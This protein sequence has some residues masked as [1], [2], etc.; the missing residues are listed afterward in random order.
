M[1]NV[2]YRRLNALGGRMRREILTIDG[3][4]VRRSTVIARMAERTEQVLHA[5]T[6]DHWR[7]GQRWYADAYA[8][9]AHVGMAAGLT[10]GPDAVRFGADII[11]I[12]SPGCGWEHNVEVA[13]DV[14]VGVR[15]PDM[16]YRGYG[17]MLARAIEYRDS[18][19]NGVLTVNHAR[20]AYL[21]GQKVSAFA[22]TIES[23][24]TFHEAVIDRHMAEKVYGMRRAKSLENV[25]VFD[26]LGDGVARVA[27]KVGMF[28]HEVQA[29]VWCAV[30]PAIVWDDVLPTPM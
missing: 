28:P 13:V 6:A 14:A 11:A 3:A 10:E 7:E 8:M 27:R 17:N 29:I 4:K 22:R 1:R 18:V 30:R 19:V 24:F 16:V 12:L 26:A 25:G 9:A 2:S 15:Q 21:R 23:P 5:A 20:E